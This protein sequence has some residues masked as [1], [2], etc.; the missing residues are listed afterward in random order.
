MGSG[1]HYSISR[2]VW[3]TRTHASEYHVTI[4]WFLADDGSWWRRT[5][6]REGNRG[7]LSRRLA[8]L[9]RLV[10]VLHRR[11]A[12]RKNRLARH[13]KKARGGCNGRRRG[14]KNGNSFDGR[15]AEQRSH[16][17][18]SK[19]R[20]GLNQGGSR[21]ESARNPI[22]FTFR[23]FLPAV[24]SRPPSSSPPPPSPLLHRP[25]YPGDSLSDLIT[26]T[27]NWICD[28]RESTFGPLGLS[29]LAIVPVN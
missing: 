3:I 22:S 7:K 23:P 10:R 11:T 25:G 19:R 2:A 9:L 15:F 29:W 12:A 27:F 5:K 14:R 1:K 6:K 21:A 20:A 4:N 16:Y 26:A 17:I 13:G 28:Q 24:L 8:D 18:F